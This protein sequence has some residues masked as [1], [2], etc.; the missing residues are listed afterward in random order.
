[1]AEAKAGDKVLVH[2]SGSLEDGSVF[3]YSYEDEPLEVTIGEKRILPSLEK[4]IIGMNEGDTKNISF[5]PENGFGYRKEDLVFQIERSKIPTGIDLRLGGVL[6]V[7]SDTRKNFDVAIT[8][9]DDKIVTLDGNH[10]LA[11]K[12]LNFKIQLVGIL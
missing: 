1:M 4:A 9:I 5:S 11:G 10:P 3:S 2:Y 7:G 12:I 8:N 6:R